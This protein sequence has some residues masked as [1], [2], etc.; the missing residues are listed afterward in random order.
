MKIFVAVACLSIL[1]QIAS[2]TAT[3]EEIS[4]CAV[5]LAPEVTL[6]NSS[7]SVK[8]SW[9]ILITDKTYDAAKK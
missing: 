2:A 9:L 6:I 4:A 1:T 5:A 3:K 8:K 7:E